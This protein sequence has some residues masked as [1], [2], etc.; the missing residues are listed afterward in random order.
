MTDLEGVF[1]VLKQLNKKYDNKL[2]SSEELKEETAN[3]K[4][5]PQIKE[6]LIKTLDNLSQLDDRKE[7]KSELIQLHLIVGEMWNGK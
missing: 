1:K 6:K 2:I 4:E 3:I 7:I 5:L